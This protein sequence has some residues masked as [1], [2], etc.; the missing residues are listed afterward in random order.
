MSGP[1]RLRSTN[2]ADSAED[3]PVLGPG[4]NKARPTDAG[5]KPASKKPE[6]PLQE[7]EKKKALA[8]S[9]PPQCMKVPSILRQQQQQEHHRHSLMNASFSSEA[10]SSDSSLS[11]HSERAARRG[12]APLRRKQ[13][14]FL[15]AEKAEND[16]APVSKMG[17]GNAV[18]ADSEGCLD[19]KKRCA[20]ITPNTDQCYIAFHDNEWGVPVHDDKKLLELLSLSGALAEL[21]WPAIL[22]KRHIF[23]EVF[24]DFDP[25]AVSKLNEKKITSLGSL[26][27]SLLS[28]LKLRAM[29]ENA[30][31][32]CKKKTDKLPIWFTYVRRAKKNI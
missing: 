19:F 22:N 27:S 17:G 1:P 6:N 7:P 29:I 15:K 9:P 26:A 23:R 12:V 14:G 28:E 31:Q 20:W 3:R 24:L 13:C 16:R 2:I 30:R 8:N 21:A 4:G 18:T 11:P 10:S 25:V 32:M 5:R